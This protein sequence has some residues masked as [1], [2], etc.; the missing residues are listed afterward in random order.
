MGSV[1]VITL[2]QGEAQG[3]QTHLEGIGV[4]IQT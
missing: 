1:R 2:A 3:L 4:E